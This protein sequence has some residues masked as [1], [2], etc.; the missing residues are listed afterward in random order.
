MLDFVVVA[1][2]VLVIVLAASI[3]LVRV[4]RQFRLHKQIQLV[5]AIMLLV[6]VV[7]F[8]VDVRFFTAWRTLAAES[9][10][11]ESGMVDL[12][13]WVHLFFAIPTPLVW[14]YTIVMAVK[15]IPADPRPCEYSPRHRFWGWTSSILLLMTAITGWIFYVLAFAL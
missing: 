2:V 10:W 15:K 1:M 13:L 4:R 12:S 14:I 9:A 6:T 8:E 3:Y 11:Y 5:T 7:A